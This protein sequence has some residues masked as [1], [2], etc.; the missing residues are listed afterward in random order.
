MEAR[1]RRTRRERQQRGENEG[2][3]RESTDAWRGMKRKIY[4]QMKKGGAYTWKEELEGDDEDQKGKDGR[5]VET[6]KEEERRKRCKGR[7]KV[8]EMK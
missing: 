8:N 1:K 4:N 3:L 7:R 2:D 5:K 6:G